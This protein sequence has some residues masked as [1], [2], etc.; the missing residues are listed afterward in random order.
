LAHKNSGGERK[1]RREAFVAGSFYPDRGEAL[2]SE[3]EALVPS[4]PEAEKHEVIGAI[5]PHAGYLYSGRVAG[6]VYGRIKN[7]DTFVIIGPNHTG[8]GN[9]FSL[10]MDVW[11]TPIGE[12]KTDIHLAEEII[13]KAPFIKNDPASH[14]AEHSIE[15]QLPFI[16]KLFPD[17][18]IVPL[19]VS[20]SDI[21]ELKAVGEAIAASVRAL[22]KKVTILASSDM[23]H[24]EPRI[25]ASKKDK[26]AIEAVLAMDAPR[27]VETIDTEKI[28]MCGWGPSAI[29]LFAARELGAESGELVTYSD[30]GEITGNESEVVGYAGIILK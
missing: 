5:V 14:A 25:S 26:Q 27:L 22:G 13:K 7:R 10:S 18:L 16:K 4:M 29:M 12:I 19:C 20:S 11:A 8:M 1:V 24:Y 6:D 28:S 15:V 23:T 17:A 21:F 30:S 9:R 2:L 3:I